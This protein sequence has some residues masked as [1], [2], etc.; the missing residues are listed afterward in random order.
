MRESVAEI[1]N[2]GQRAGTL[3]GSTTPS[4]I[5]TLPDAA[6]GAALYSVNCAACHQA[7]GRGVQGVF[8]SLANDPIVQAADP[9]DHIRTVLNG[10]RGSVIGGVTY[11]SPM[12]AFKDLLNDVDLAAIINHERTSWGKRGSDRQRVRRGEAA[13]LTITYAEE[14]LMM[15]TVLALDYDGTIASDGVLNP[16]VRRAIADLAADGFARLRAFSAH[17]NRLVRVRSTSSSPRP[18][19]TTSAIYRAKPLT[20]LLTDT[21][22]DRQAHVFAA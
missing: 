13:R 5:A 22:Y 19:R 20:C 6:R 14:S 7:T 17:L 3:T 11:A 16:E 10:R 18:L 1:H 12:P 4:S 8:P 15:F 21:M 9:T 2:A